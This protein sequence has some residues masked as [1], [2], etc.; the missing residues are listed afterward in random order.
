MRS[1]AGAARWRLRSG[2]LRRVLCVHAPHRLRGTTHRL[3]ACMLTGLLAAAGTSV[4]AVPCGTR[5]GAIREPTTSDALVVLEA[6]VGLPG[7][8]GP[9]LCDVDAGGTIT[10]TDA[11]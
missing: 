6:A 5:D 7:R 10:A 8:C 11:V 3:Q 2:L 4:A 9:C 1:P